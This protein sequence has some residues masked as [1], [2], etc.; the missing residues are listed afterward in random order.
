MLKLLLII[1]LVLVII[2]LLEKVENFENKKIVYVFWTGDNEMSENRKKCLETIRKNIG[3]N[4]VLVTPTNLH[5]YEKKEFP[6]HRAYKYL[7]YIHKSDY[8]R[9]YFMHH[10]GGGYTDIKNT[11]HNWNKYFDILN[12]DNNIWAIGYP[13]IPGGSA[14]SNEKIRTDYEKLIGNC[15]YI[16]KP[17]TPFTQEWIDRLH[18]KLDNKYEELKKYPAKYPREYIGSVKYEKEPSKYPLRWTEILGEH[19]HDVQ[20][21]YTS[22]VKNILPTINSENYK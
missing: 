8:L 4:V 14:S 10:Y 1:V 16:F 9:T 5:K 19:F 17:Y 22:H 2:Y 11:T 21:K 12:N 18:K 7:S 3:V 15:A 20:Y 13:E 6:I